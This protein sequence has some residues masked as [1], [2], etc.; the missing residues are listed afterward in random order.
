M[1][2]TEKGIKFSKL[3]TIGIQGLHFGE[4]Q[5]ISFHLSVCLLDADQP[6]QEKWLT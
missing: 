2:N 3:E 5:D 4:E 6:I 1:W